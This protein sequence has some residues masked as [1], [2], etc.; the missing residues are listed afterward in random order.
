V[1][2]NLRK[3]AALNAIQIAEE[4]LKRGCLKPG[5][6][7][8]VAAASPG[9]YDEIG[10]GS[11]FHED[12]AYYEANRHQLSK[13][14]DGKFV[15]IVDSAVVDSDDEFGTL[16]ERIYTT[17]GY[18]PILMT[19]VDTEPRVLNVRSPRVAER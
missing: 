14:Y 18:R 4:V 12:W 1:A 7:A 10:R 5:G 16:S 3:G 11:T 8:A 6:K 19:R 9:L 2:D 13:Q 17:Y 15:A